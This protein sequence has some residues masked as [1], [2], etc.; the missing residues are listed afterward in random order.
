MD[1]QKYR[2]LIKIHLH[3]Q[4]GSFLVSDAVTTWKSLLR[5]IIQESAPTLSTCSN[6]F[7]MDFTCFNNESG[8][9]ATVC[10]ILLK[11]GVTRVVIAPSSL[12]FPKRKAFS[13]TYF[14]KNKVCNVTSQVL[15]KI[16]W[17]LILS[18]NEFRSLM[19]KFQQFNINFRN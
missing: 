17:N 11:D 1:A 12:F 7:C 19:L 13:F 8:S 14:S 18:A 15:H 9:T 5:A 4:N 3:A 6:P 2:Y 10:N 16:V